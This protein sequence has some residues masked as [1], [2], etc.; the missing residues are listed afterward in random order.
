MLFKWVLLLVFLTGCHHCYR[1]RPLSLD[2][3]DLE[4]QVEKGKSSDSFC[5]GNWETDAWWLFF[6]DPE[7]TK[8]IE[9]SLACHPDM[10]V[11]EARICLAKQ[12][13]MEAQSAL[14]P[15]LFF[16]GDIFRQKASEYGSLR[17][18]LGWFTETTLLLQANYEI[19]LWRKNR[20]IFYA[21]ID[22]YLA[23]VAEAEQAKLILS[24][25]VANAYFNLQ[26][27]RERLTIAEERLIERKKVYDLFAQ[28]FSQGIIAESKLFETD[29]EMKL[30]QEA[31]DMLIGLIAI[32]EHV[33][34]ALVGNVSCEAPSME[35]IDP[36]VFLSKPV[37]LP[38]SLPFDLLARRPD[39]IAQK[40][41]V[42]AACF[43]IKAAQARFFP[44]L[45][46]LAYIGFQSILI[47]KLFSYD[48]LTMHGEATGVLPLFTGGK[49][50][51]QLGVAQETLEIAIQE[52]NQTVLDAIQ[53]VSDA[54]TDLIT[55]DEREKSAVQAIQDAKAILNLNENKFSHGIANLLP[56]LEAEDDLLI[57]EDILAQI[58]LER[59]Q[60]ALALIQAIGGGYYD[61]SFE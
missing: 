15:H 41:R 22:R 9:L 20:S 37:P 50:C 7:L 43:E 11:A 6:E 46:L 28:Q 58:E 26:I 12:Q 8:L 57:Q 56:V 31:I 18:G 3:T 4:E 34:S 54:I 59:L 1:G 35:C 2:C 48:A 24:T 44:N 21:A 47:D 49:L 55:A 29:L 45:N 13:A 51:A 25:S 61:C 40:W 5:T 33:L 10:K 42:E 14:F 17:G 30:I 38:A 36:E 27:H 39:I 32:D 60:A 19:D 52:Y 16:I 23:W 53:Q